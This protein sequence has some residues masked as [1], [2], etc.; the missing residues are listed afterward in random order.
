ME[1]LALGE[2]T[3]GGWVAVIPEAVIPEV[4]ILEAGTPGVAI[5]AALIREEA[6]PAERIQPAVTRVAVIRA[7]LFSLATT[8]AA[9]LGSL[10]LIA[11]YFHMITPVNL[12]ANLLIVPLS[13]LTLVANAGALACAGWAPYLTSLFNHTGWFTIDGFTH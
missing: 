12:P 4:A 9:W 2:D 13:S 11:Y 5:R 6:I 8:M 7:V 1:R 3:Q 10:P